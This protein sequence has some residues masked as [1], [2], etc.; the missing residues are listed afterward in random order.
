MRRFLLTVLLFAA[1]C[2]G[3]YGS[4]IDVGTA[5]TVARNWFGVQ[6]GGKTRSGGIE[7]QLVWTGNY[8]TRG[9]MAPPFY[10]FNNPGGGWVVIS[11]E[12]AARPVLARSDEGSFH[13]EE[14]PDIVSEWFDVYAK[15]IDWIRREGLQPDD[16]TQARWE[17]LLSEEG[18]SSAAS[19]TRAEAVKML[20]TAPW[21]QR[22]PFNNMCFTIDGALPPCGCTNTAAAEIMFYYRHPVGRSLHIPSYTYTKTINNVSR[23]FTVPAVEDEVDYDWA[24]MRNDKYPSGTYSTVEGDAVAKLISDLS[25]MTKTKFGPSG[26]G[27]SLSNLR[28]GMIKYMGYDPAMLRVNRDDYSVEEWR[29][30]LIKEIDEGR[31]MVYEGYNPEST[32]TGHAFV[33]DGYD[34]EGAF[35]IN[36]GWSG[37]YSGS[38]AF[39]AVDALTPGTR[40]YNYNQHALIYMMPA[41]GETTMQLIDYGIALENPDCAPLSGQVFTVKA[42]VYNYGERPSGVWFNVFHADFRNNPVAPLSTTTWPTGTTAQFAPDVEREKTSWRCKAPA[43]SMVGDRIMLFYSLDQGTQWYPFTATESIT[44]PYSIPIYDLPYI[45]SNEDGIYKSGESILLRIVNVRKAPEGVTWYFDGETVVPDKSGNFRVTS[46]TPGHHTIKAEI[47]NEEGT[48]SIFQEI[49][50]L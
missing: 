12:D 1:F 27:A 2:C 22:A 16:A 32:S 34:S 43:E 24:H 35:H 5:E 50:V 38:S 40:N 8:S 28:N 30:L 49:T 47:I 36:W 9:P 15:Q 23:T 13:P 44:V 42:K 11:A 14:I 31:P 45:D 4:A 21:G 6:S 26:S 29:A 20:G 39:F 37:S 18:A 46:L 7:P 48:Q 41:A 19:L 3:A 17:A 33:L 10:V 25:V